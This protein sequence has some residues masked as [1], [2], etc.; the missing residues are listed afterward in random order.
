MQIVLKE[1]REA[2]FGAK[3]ILESKLIA[4][5]DDNLKFQITES[6][7]LMNIIAKAIVTAKN[8]IATPQSKKI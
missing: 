6:K 5:D 1:L 4:S 7:A 2:H 3:L 8:N